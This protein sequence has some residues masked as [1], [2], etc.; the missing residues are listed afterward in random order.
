MKFSA[1]IESSIKVEG[2]FGDCCGVIEFFTADSHNYYSLWRC[3]YLFF[4]LR[5]LGK[6][7]LMP[8]ASFRYKFASQ[9]F[10]V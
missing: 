10:E 8:A 2:V 5:L 4:V 6:D 3:S 9:Q 1:D 7:E